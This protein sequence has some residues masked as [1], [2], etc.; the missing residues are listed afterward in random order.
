MHVS[1]VQTD[2]YLQLR[3]SVSR[4]PAAASVRASGSPMLRGD[5]VSSGV[6]RGHRTL[7]GGC[8]PPRSRSRSGRSPIR[9]VIAI[10]N[11][12][13]LNEL[14][15]RNADLTEATRAADGHQR[16]P[17]GHLAARRPTSSRCSTSSP[18]AR[19]ASA[20]R[21]WRRH[22]F[23]GELIHIAAIR[24][25]SPR[26]A[27]RSPAD[28]PDAPSGAGA[29]GGHIRDRA[30]SSTSPDVTADQRIPDP[31]HGSRRR[32]PRACCACRCSARVARSAP[33]PSTGPRPALQRTAGPAADD[34]RRPGG[35]R[36]RERPPVHR[37]A[38]AQQRARRVALE[39]QTATSEVLKVI[40]RSTVRPAAGASD[41]SSRVPRRLCEADAARSACPVL[42]ALRSG[43]G[44]DCAA[45][46][47]IRQ[48]FISTNS[49]PARPGTHGGARRARTAVPSTS[50]TSSTDPEYTLPRRREV[51][52]HPT[53]LAMPMLGQTSCIGVIRV[54]QRHEVRPF[55]DKQ[56]ALRPDLRRSGRH[57]HRERAPVQRAAGAQ[58]ATSPRR[59]SSRRRRARSCA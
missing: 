22:R 18:S 16:D 54:I 8:C 37:A 46:S 21:K 51:G 10:E 36:H 5:D 56:I 57:R 34:L 33:S 41:T 59:W 30:P 23:D 53:V 50:R 26:G 3:A 6:S 32:L 17:P 38:D 25:S 49:D 11:A 2:P 27:R 13:L 31:G 24:G 4:P 35:H 15:A 19:S 52:G 45:H 28:L 48:A 43:A 40:S 14:Q 7:A 12:R 39:Q 20:V 44:P 55:T 58:R 9:P 42:T 47:A 1:D 29:R